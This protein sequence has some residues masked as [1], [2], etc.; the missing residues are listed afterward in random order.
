MN[1][2]KKL[3]DFIFNQ[4]GYELKEDHDDYKVYLLHQGMYYGAE[5]IALNNCNCKHVVD[6]YS[7]LGYA[8]K[9]HQFGKFEEVEKYL[10]DGFFKTALT[11][12]RIKKRYQEFAKSQMKL[13][14]NQGIKYEYVNVPYN[15][16]EGN[17]FNKKNNIIQ[18][19]REL[20]SKKGAYLIIIEAAAGFG[21]TCTAFE[22]Y[23]S[24]EPIT[25]ETKPLFAELS[26]NRNAKEFR[27][28]LMS[29]IEDEFNT[30]LN[31]D[32]VVYNIKRGKIPLI[33]DGFDELLSKNIDT[34][35]VNKTSDFEEVE[36]MLSTIGDLLND[37]AKIIITSRKTAIFSGEQFFDWVDSYNDSF[38]VVRF[39]LEKPEIEHWLPSDRIDFLKSANVPLE[40]ISNP[41]LLTY[42]RNIDNVSFNSLCKQPDSIVDHYFKFLLNRERERQQLIIPYEDQLLIY[43]NLARSFTVF[44]ITAEARSFIKDLIIEYNK[45]KL[46]YYRELSNPK[47]TFEELAN[48]LTNHALLD[49]IGNKDYVGF[50]NEF[51]FGI[52]LGRSFIKNGLPNDN[53]ESRVPER[54]VEKIVAAFQYASSSDKM[55]L[56]TVIYPIKNTFSS[57]FQIQFDS[58]LTNKVIGIY[59]NT[60]V[61]SIDFNDVSFDN[62]ESAFDAI[63]WTN[64]TFT[65]CSFDKNIFHGCSFIGCRFIDCIVND[66]PNSN[67]NNN[68]CYGCNDYNTGF[69][70][71]FLYLKDD[72]LCD[73][74]NLDF[75][76][77]VLSM[78]FKVD[79]KTPRMRTISSL[80]KEVEIEDLSKELHKLEKSGYIIINGNNS[81]ITKEGISFY[82]KNN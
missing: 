59:S 37:N 80:K 13:Y 25:S 73:S 29:E 79:G 41:V 22:I 31:T 23:N 3:L 5:V 61:D 11:S 53:K 26:N 45:D 38:R 64:I 34:G 48:A 16:L 36:T 39:Q 51:V 63:V 24:L 69:I 81:F 66:L 44:D 30:G 2:D 19:I 28:V 42:L 54:I 17:E 76:T 82:H 46:Q 52:L 7:K 18:D 1:M 27:Y 47:R 70:N 9:Y 75:E 56:Y 67:I 57:A 50:I 65:R 60:N 15:I 32:L 58:I 4:Y 6:E 35:I 40:N 49:R 12:S 68:A 43:M 20:F 74:I 62:K 33:I 72:N 77:V 55:Q 78:Y 14:E 10:F 21:K 8:T 71:Q